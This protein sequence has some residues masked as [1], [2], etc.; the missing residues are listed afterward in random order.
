VIVPSLPFLKVYFRS[1]WPSLFTNYV[2]KLHALQSK[3]RSDSP[4]KNTTKSSTIR[5]GIFI[6]QP[7]DQLNS[8]LDKPAPSFQSGLEL[9]TLAIDDFDDLLDTLDDPLTTES[10]Q[11]RGFPDLLHIGI[12]GRGMAG[13]YTEMILIDLKL[14]YE[15]LE[16]SGRPGGRVRTHRFSNFPGDYYDVGAMRFP[17]IPIMRPTLQLFH[18]LG[19]TKDTTDKPAQ[20]TLIPYH[21]KG[22]NNTLYDNNILVP[23]GDPKGDPSKVSVK[24]G[25]TV[26]N[27][28][29]SCADETLWNVGAD[30]E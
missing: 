28:Y 24:N 19:I 10:A 15:V 27:V 18:K 26:P 8:T 3:S 9:D 14:S 29:V 4:S 21:F 16:A 11:T 2:P 5:P 17:E 30:G 1:R 25:G 22:Q 20:G 7:T 12:V 23:D 6:L 13:L